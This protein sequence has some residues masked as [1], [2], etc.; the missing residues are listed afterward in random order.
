MHGWTHEKKVSKRRVEYWHPSMK[1]CWSV[2]RSLMMGVTCSNGS[3]DG[4]SICLV[5]AADCCR[6]H[7]TGGCKFRTGVRAIEDEV[8]QE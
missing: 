1:V 8:M 6:G 3:Q 5:V 4:R 2:T 7:D